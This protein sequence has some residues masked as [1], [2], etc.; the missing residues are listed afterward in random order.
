MTLLTDKLIQLI[1][2]DMKEREAF[3]QKKYNSFVTVYNN[4]NL[5]QESYEEILDL[6]VY[7]KGHILRLQKA[8]EVPSVWQEVMR[9]LEELT[10]GYTV[11]I[12]TPLSRVYWNSIQNLYLIKQELLN[13]NLSKE[14]L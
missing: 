11:D 12:S 7:L 4:R 10:K 8:S 13:Q 2:S 9:D 3:G 1:L 14:T 6:C 5:L